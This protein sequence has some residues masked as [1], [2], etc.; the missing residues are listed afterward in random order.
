MFS[1]FCDLGSWGPLGNLG[2]WGW[3]GLILTLL[4][5]LALLAAVTLLVFWAKRRARV[6]PTTARHTA[7]EPTAKEILRTRY[8]RGEI[9]LEQFELMK[10]VTG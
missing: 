2:A 10:Q 6:R 9:T 3:I 1:G 8:A 7:G 5:W 4:F